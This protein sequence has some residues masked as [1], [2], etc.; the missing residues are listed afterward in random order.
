[1]SK[2]IGVLGGMGSYATVEF[3]KMILDNFNVQ[4]E[5]EYPKIL[6]YNNPQ[7]PS[8]TRAVL[9]NEES[10]EQGLIEGCQKLERSGADFIVIPCNSAQVWHQAILKKVNIPVINIII[11]VK[12]HI[13]SN[14]PTMRKIGL[15]SGEVPIQKK[16]YNKEFEEKEI[17]ILLADTKIQIVVREIIDAVK[18]N[19]HT[20]E[21]KEKCLRV[22]HHFLNRGAEGIILGCTELSL[23]LKAQDSS[24]PL[25]D[26]SAILAAKVAALSRE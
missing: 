16:L 23:V 1:M 2:T 19:H 14:F 4:R 24:V 18:H 20:V 25:F 3:F 6:I 10:P 26:S 17:E 15:I 5:W 13:L 12:E 21:T 8:R 9:F 7:L 11:V 22:I